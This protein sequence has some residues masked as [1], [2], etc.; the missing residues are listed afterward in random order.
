MPEAF[1]AH[2]TLEKVQDR[3]DLTHHSLSQ[4]AHHDSSISILSMPHD[5]KMHPYP[6]KGTD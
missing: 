5:R 6:V 2:L 1:T 4:Q 3:P